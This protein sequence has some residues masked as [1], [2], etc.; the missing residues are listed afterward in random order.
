MYFHVIDN[1]L[2]DWSFLSD[3]SYLYVVRS[4]HC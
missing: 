1:K 4:V 3:I 2:D